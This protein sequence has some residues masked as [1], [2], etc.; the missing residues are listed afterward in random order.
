MRTTIGIEELESRLDLLIGKPVWAIR[1]GGGSC[2]IIDCGDRVPR[3]EIWQEHGSYEG[4]RAYQGE[5]TLMIS[6]A[7]RVEREGVGIVS[8]TGD[9]EDETMLSGPRKL[10]GQTVVGVSV[11][12]FID[13]L[14]AFTGGLRLRLFCDQRTDDLDTEFCYTLFVRAEGAYTVGNNMITLEKA[15]GY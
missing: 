10:V 3:Q 13:L 6:C 11:E 1:Y 7:W 15:R 12:P 14:V 8:G 2:L 5:L 9:L 4:D